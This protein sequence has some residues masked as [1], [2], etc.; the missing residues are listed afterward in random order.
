MDAAEPVR[1]EEGSR[2]GDTIKTLGTRV[3]VMKSQE[4]ETENLTNSGPVV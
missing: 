3:S 2:K 1:V 4:A